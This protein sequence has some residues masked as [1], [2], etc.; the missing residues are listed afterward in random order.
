M[1]HTVAIPLSLLLAFFGVNATQVD[2]QRSMFDPAY[3]WIYLAVGLLAAVTIV[4]SV[5]LQITQQRHRRRGLR[6][7]PREFLTNRPPTPIPR[8]EAGQ[9]DRARS[10]PAPQGVR[11]RVGPS[12]R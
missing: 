6:N 11:R 1:S 4:L 9:V 2:E 12:H 3:I 7:G 8:R 5:T 10:R